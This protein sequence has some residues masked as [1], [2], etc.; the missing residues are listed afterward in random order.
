MRYLTLVSI[1][2]VLGCGL[3]SGCA[4]LEQFILAG[5]AVFNGGAMPGATDAT[6]TTPS[7]RP[8][9]SSNNT[10]AR[11]TSSSS[12]GKNFYCTGDPNGGGRATPE[13]SALCHY[14]TPP[15]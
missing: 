13:T 11:A 7:A 6:T 9:P 5:N 2:L 8:A 15:K 1:N 12:A 4:A 3:L 10:A 14:G